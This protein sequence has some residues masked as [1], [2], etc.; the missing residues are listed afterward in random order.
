MRTAR[1]RV[2]DPC[3]EDYDAMRGSGT[4]RFCDR[5]S[6]SVTNLS[7]MTRAE[8]QRFL[9]AH[10]GERVCVRYRSRAGQVQ[11]RPST[12]ARLAF[13]AAISVALAACTGYVEG[14]EL[15]SPDDALVCHDA[16]GYAV[17]CE[18]LDDGVIPV[19]T[20]PAGHGEDAQQDPTPP[21]PDDEVRTLGKI[22]V[23]PAVGCPI[24]PPNPNVPDDD[25]AMGAVAYE[26]ELMGV[27]ESPT[28]AEIRRA[29]RQQRRA[30]RV[31]RRLARRQ[32]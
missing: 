14:D 3:S 11:F 10:A 29:E 12:P 2:L 23:D 4:T 15:D 17:P 21:D 24:P 22:V 8:A 18:Q 32:R 6:K 28:H 9:E 25:T 1:L 16:S 30:A 5:C 19:D 31:E 26:R 13:V 7:D 20:P 27:I